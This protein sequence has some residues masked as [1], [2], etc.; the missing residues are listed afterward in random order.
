MELLLGAG[1]LGLLVGA[2]AGAGGYHLVGPGREPGS[3]ERLHRRFGVDSTEEAVETAERRLDA[4]AAAAE[5]ATEAGLIADGARGA[6]VGRLPDAIERASAR[7]IGARRDR[8]S[9]P[10]DGAAL[11]PEPSGGRPTAGVGDPDRVRREL[12][13]AVGERVA[14]ETEPVAAAIERL[15]RAESTA[16]AGAAVATLV[17]RADEVVRAE[18]VLES[19]GRPI[20]PTV[21]TELHETVAT[22][23]GPLWKPL[24]PVTAELVDATEARER[25]RGRGRAVAA[26]GELCD[27]A[28][29]V[30]ETGSTG[31][32]VEAL[33]GALDD[34]RLRLIEGDSVLD[35]SLERLARRSADRSRRARDLLLALRTRED[36]SAEELTTA[37]ERAVEAIDERSAVGTLVG[38]VD[39]AEAI[40]AV[41]AVDE[42][43]D[44]EWPIASLLSDRTVDLRAELDR[45][46]DPANVRAHAIH[47]EATYYTETLLPGLAARRTVPPETAAVRDRIDTIEHRCD[48]LQEH[49]LERRT[50]HNH[51][52]PRHYFGLVRALCAE[53]DELA[54][55]DPQQAAGLVAA[56]ADVLEHTEALYER[57]EY[58]VM[59]RRLRG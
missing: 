45:D 14:P 46:H 1:L 19:V 24:E 6:A 22:E 30:P 52:I 42:A 41:E 47:R 35:E 59:L 17:E 57:N 34:G 25:D 26:A 15:E 12:A 9:D 29:L 50:D 23:T 7:A 13:A 3:V 53:A 16:E 36:R 2:V 8:P 10:D 44:P 11:P 58:S 20:D 21:A 32:R 54:P 31:D 43:L 55:T 40:A 48:E 39:R 18:S 51:S 56:A 49:F 33:L 38:T 4:A 37:L 27:R 28:P 5:R